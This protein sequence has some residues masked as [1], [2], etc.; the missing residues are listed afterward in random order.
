M[1]KRLLWIAVPLALLGAFWL[2]SRSRP[3]GVD[4]G[5]VTRGPIRSTVEEEGRT[6][7]IDRFVVSVP[8]AGRLLRVDLEEGDAVKKGQLL[9]RVD[10]L[11]LQTSVAEVEAQIRGVRQQMDGVETKI[12]KPEEIERAKVLETQAEEALEVAQRELE[13]ATASWDRYVKDLERMKDLAEDE[14]VADADLDAAIEAEAAA[15]EGVLAQEVRIKIARLAISATRLNRAVLE[16]RLHDFDWEKKAYAQQIAGLEAS[17]ERLQDDLKRTDIH[18]PADGVVLRVLQ[19]SETV[20]APGTPILE[21]GDV[22]RLEVE[23]DYLS[24]DAAHMRVGMKAEIFGRALGSRVLP[25]TVARIHPSAFLKISSLGVE[26]Q[27]VYVILDFD[28]AGSG[29]GDRYRIEA[30]VILEERDDVLLVPEGALFRQQEAWHAFVLEG[31]RARLRRVETN[32]R[33]GRAREVLDGLAEGDR[34]VLHPGD[35]LSD[36]TRVKVLEAAEG[37]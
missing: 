15:R 33:D 7:V 2:F 22:S 19:E 10:P 31:D 37:R 4:V 6:R 32:L 26:Q 28:P 25:A 13:R 18:A 1:L 30:R 8:V 14:I 16:S 9:A 36:G 17:L 5:V 21:I 29:L 24:E 35:A 12:P 27:R 20:V 11:P 23:V 34:V 3:V